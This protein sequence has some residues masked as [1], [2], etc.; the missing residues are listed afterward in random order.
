MDINDKQF[1]VYRWLLENDE[2]PSQRELAT[3]LGINRMAVN[4]SLVVLE[5]L[6]AIRADRED[7]TRGYMI[8]P[9]LEVTMTPEELQA[10]LNSLS[11]LAKLLTMED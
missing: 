8:M 11:P 2:R 3:I 5:W 9:T 4:R 10:K 1:D 6:G 7:T